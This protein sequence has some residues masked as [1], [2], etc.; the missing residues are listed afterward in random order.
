MPRRRGTAPPAARRAPRSWSA[1]PRSARAP[2]CSERSA[3]SC[4]WRPRERQA[5]TT[6]RRARGNRSPRAVYRAQRLGATLTHVVRV[7]SEGVEPLAAALA[8]RAG[9]ELDPDILGSRGLEP[10]VRHD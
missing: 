6:W 1:G 9:V 2:R 4:G 3:T 8:A 10:H 7:A 5:R